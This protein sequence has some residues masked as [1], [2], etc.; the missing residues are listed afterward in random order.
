MAD[1]LPPF[2]PFRQHKTTHLLQVFDLQLLE[3]AG[4]FRLLH[5]RKLIRHELVRFGSPGQGIA[6]FTRAERFMCAE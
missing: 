3:G 5:L 6:K 1:Q 4:N 2:G